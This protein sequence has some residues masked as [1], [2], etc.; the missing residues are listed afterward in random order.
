MAMNLEAVLRISA[1]VVGMEQLTGLERGL[2]SAET[3]AG[4]AR[5]AF[6]AVANS[7]IWQ[8][9]AAGAAVF[10]GGIALATR[11]A[12]DFESSM[13]DVRKVVSGIETPAAFAEIS[14]EILSLSTQMPIAA[15][16]FAQIYAAAGQSGIA[17]SELKEF[18]IAVG[19]VSVAF[20]MTAEEAGTAMAQMRAALGLTTPELVLLTDAI[21]EL[22]NKSQGALTAGNLVEFMTRA[23]AIGKLSGLSAEQTAAFGATMIQA[24]VEANVAAT[25]FRNLVGALTSGPSMTQKQVD[26]LRTLGYTMADAKEIESQLTK[27]AETESRRRVD[28]ARGQKD[29]VIQIAQEQS[30]RRVEAARNETD[31]LSRE[32]NRRYRDELQVL[33]DGWEDQS[34]AQED[35]SRD[36]AEAQIKALQKQEKAEID[37]IEKIAKAQGTDATLAVERIRDSYEGRI[38][39][40]RDTLDKELTLQRRVARDEQQ[41]VRD[42]LDDRKMQEL[43]A[44]SKRLK[45]VEEHEKQYMDSQKGAAE[46][47][48]K[49]VQ[50]TEKQF[51]ETAKVQARKAGDEK[52]RA[53]MQGFA[54]RMQADA[55]GTIT[56]LFKRI[57]A[58]PKAQQLS[59]LTDF[60]GEEGARSVALLVTEFAKL[61]NSL[62]IV[63]DKGNYAGSV[64]KEYAARVVTAAS[65]IQLFWNELNRL[66]IVIGTTV[67]PYISMVT[68]AL[69]PMI[70]GFAQ[71]A[72][73]NPGIAAAAVAIGSVAAAVVIALPALAAI[74]VGLSAL[75]AAFLA[76]TI[77]AAVAGWGTALAGFVAAIATAVPIII[78]HLT[79]LMVWMG[80]IFLKGFLAVFLSPLGLTILAVAAVVAMA[81]AFREPLMQFVTWLGGLLGRALQ[82]IEEWASGIPQLVSNAWNASKTVVTKFFAWFGNAVADGLKA[83]WKWAQPIQEFWTKTWNSVKGVVGG[84]F[85]WFARAITSGLQ[86]LWKWGEPIRTFWQG[87]WKGVETFVTA[88]FQFVRGVFD[89]GLKAAWAIVDTLFIRPWINTWENLIRKP[90][91]EAQNWLSASVFKPLSQAFMEQ[92]VIPIQGAW[93][94]MTAIVRDATD[95]LLG[96]VG[97]IWSRLSQQFVQYAVNPIRETWASITAF[98][99]AAVGTAVKSV[100]GAWSDLGRMFTSGVVTPVRNAWQGLMTLLPELM[101]KAGNLISDMWKG[102]KNGFTTYVADPILGVWKAVTEALPNAM[103]SAASAIGTFWNGM[104]STIKEA[105]RGMLQYLANGVNY[106]AGLVNRLIG[107]FNVLAKATGGRTM[108]YIPTVNVPEFAKGGVVSR[109]TLA[110]V[111]EGGE[112]E[113]VIPESKMA[114]ASSRFM[115]GARGSAVIPSNSTSAP[116][117]SATQIN[118]TTGPVLQTED[119]QKYVTMEDFERGLRQVS[120][121]TLSRLRS[122][123]ARIALGLT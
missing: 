29:Q 74:V 2:N 5:S 25:G 90:V 91:T 33:Q 21:N 67:L 87:V 49:N 59:V 18:A 95:R 114:A 100:S 115:G 28:A 65:Q 50:E 24:G 35:I 42:R 43:D 3:A 111:G 52:A 88:Y 89:W 92:A 83:L 55:V 121:A 15:D 71:F 19:Q 86:S 118:I 84:F 4:Q 51:L 13:A 106:V 62:A 119:G 110:L 79:G 20:D 23:G 46:E 76:T 122:P 48:F 9:A 68:E 70:A 41:V 45:A 108:D 27:A 14:K 63:S 120:N 22:S 66:A 60:I 36:R 113:Y 34:R 82:V 6:S 10:L 54:D 123:Q 12:I 107:A 80:T 116:A 57:N 32:I 81:I 39:T 99:D 117:A 56:D 47:R 73:V 77:G 37:Y 109:P 11:A 53:D 61:E 38:G 94:G 93:T 31:R 97:A 72:M 30:D 1:N 96:A 26:A 85:A 102:L 98:L 17:R 64:T 101:A 69:R 58:I 75:K 103:R 16:G 78:G 8:A 44:N 7:A 112:R 105:V 40:V 104:I